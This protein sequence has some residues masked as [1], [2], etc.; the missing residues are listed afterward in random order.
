[1]SAKE[2]TA[3]RSEA[4]LIGIVA[5]RIGG[6]EGARPF[7]GQ[8]PDYAR[9]VALAGGAPA[10]IPLGLGEELL[11]AAYRRLDG[12]LLPGGVDVAPDRYGQGRHPRLGEVDEELDRVELLLAR[13]ALEDG[14]PVLGICRGIQLLNVAAGGTL[15]QHVPAQVSGA[16]EHA[17]RHQPDAHDVRVEPGSRLAAALGVTGCRVNSRHH[18]AVLEAAPGMA[19]TAR[20]PDGV[21]EGIEAAGQRFVVGVQWHPENLAPESPVM[22]G[23][24]RAFVEA[25]RS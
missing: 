17:L 14:L 16:L 4:P 22:L 3:G 7:D 19:V 10:L 21:I 13:W 18:Q 11:G 23:L 2:A 1:M 15:Y 24:F 20:A 8:Y 25:S 12:L 5:H 6:G 9:S